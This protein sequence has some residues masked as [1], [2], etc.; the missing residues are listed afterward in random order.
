MEGIRYDT[1]LRE[2][3]LDRGGVKLRQVTKVCK[4]ICCA[5]RLHFATPA[6]KCKM[7]HGISLWKLLRDSLPPNKTASKICGH[8]PNGFL[9][10]DV[11][12]DAQE[13]ELVFR[14][15]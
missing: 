3:R 12:S 8:C 10:I 5:W 9:F 7:L 13:H 6:G 15:A 2:H 11:L 1:A 14:D 4:I